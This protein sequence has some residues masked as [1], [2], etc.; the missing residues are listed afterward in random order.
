MKRKR[1]SPEHVVTILREAETGKLTIPEL[2]RK[3]GINEATF[4]RWRKRYLGMT[5]SDAK[6]FKQLVAE[7]TRL[8]KLL[9]ERDLEVDA[10]K[11]VLVKKA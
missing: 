10:L 8:K 1:F 4:Y 11:S 9:A 3:H 7:N 5:V 2:C 6:R